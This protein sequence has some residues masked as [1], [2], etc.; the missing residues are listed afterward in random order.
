M[1]E[2]RPLSNYSGIIK[3]LQS[4][5]TLYS[6]RVYHGIESFG[7]L[8]FDASS[9]VLTVASGSNTYWHK[10]LKYYTTSAIVCDLDDY[11]SL[12]T[13]TLYYVYFDDATGTL[14][15]DTVLWDL[16][17]K[18]PVATVYWNG[19]LGAVVPELHGHDRG[20]GW[21][22]NAH[23][24]IG[25]RYYN[26]LELIKPSTTYDSSLEI[27]SGILFDEDVQI[28][29]DPA[30]TN[31][32]IWYLVSSGKYTFVNSDLPYAGTIGSP[33]YLDTG[34]YTL[35]SVN[36][37]KFVCMWVF[38]SGDSDR[39]IYIFP[40]AGTSEHNTIALARAE[41]APNLAGFGLNPELKL[42]YRLIY[43]GN[44]EFQESADY[45]KASSLPSGTLA[46][47]SAGSVT[48]IPYSGITGTNVQSGIEQIVD[49]MMKGSSYQLDGTNQTI[50][51]DW[52]N[53]ATQRVTL[54]RT[55]HIITFSNPVEGQ[56][57]RIKLIQG[58]GGSKAITTWPTIKWA[59]GITPTLTTTAG[60][61]DIT[62]L[63][64]DNSEY[65]ADINKN[66]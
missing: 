58:S 16:R 24:T 37:S 31:C 29:I 62:T 8:S 25:C 66:F 40:S 10:G 44:G 17:L 12:T 42:L 35:T 6:A 27:S 23:L 15:A 30:K 51:I 54:T 50:A 2:K 34:S 36:S 7:G 61:Y 14:K 32:R 5:D 47:I 4:T 56:V 57:Y 19:S 22:I 63:L 46:S 38:G 55:D 18:V 60:K 26:G 59:K 13:N 11:V 64:Y 53:G 39:P 1:A 20:V 43:Q 49:K 48:F 28:K 41:G 9:H 65:S 21:H 52:S 45:R 3:E 33:S